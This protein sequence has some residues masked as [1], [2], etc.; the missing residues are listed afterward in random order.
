MT[1]GGLF[2]VRGRNSINNKT[3]WREKKNRFDFLVCISHHRKWKEETLKPLF[4]FDI[5]GCIHVTGSGL[6]L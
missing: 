2:L 5:S 1:S 3:I 6:P 4:G